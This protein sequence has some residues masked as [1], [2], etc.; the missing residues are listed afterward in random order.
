VK[1]DRVSTVS[2]RPATPDGSLKARI[3]EAARDLFFKS[4][5]VRVRADDIAA[6]LGISKATLYK[7][8]VGKEEILRAVVGRTVAEMAAAVE[9]IAR[10][11]SKDFVEKVIALMAYVKSVV[12]HMRGPLGQDIERYAPA[13]WKE[14]DE[15]R[16]KMILANFKTLIGAGVREGVLRGDIDQDVLV[17]MWVTLVQNLLTPEMVLRLPRS[18]DA[19]FE[20]MIKVIFEGLLTDKGRQQYS[21]RK[22]PLT[23]LKKEVRP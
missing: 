23:A 1:T 18:A 2:R 4:G 11:D 19:V 7:A 9:A 21:A 22:G 13:V 15:F 8:F 5:F 14:I 12:S 16:R 3:V 17:L 6:K 20:I 10:D